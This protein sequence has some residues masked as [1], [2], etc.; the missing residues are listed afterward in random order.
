MTPSEIRRVVYVNQIKIIHFGCVAIFSSTRL[1]IALV[2]FRPFT[3]ISEVEVNQ[4]DEL[5]QFLFCKRRFTDPI[6]TSGALLEGFIFAIGW[7]KFSTKNEQFGQSLRYVPTIQT[8]PSTSEGSQRLPHESLHCAGSQQFKQ[9]LNPVQA[10][11]N[12]HANAYAGAGSS[13]SKNSLRLCRLPTIHMRILTLLQV[14]TVLKI[15]QPLQASDNSHAN[16]HA[17]EGS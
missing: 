5:S 13:N 17:C 6:A 10:L 2:E 4:W 1:L 9:F 11:D 8:T 3:T 15:P 7:R 16:P 14:P 12:S